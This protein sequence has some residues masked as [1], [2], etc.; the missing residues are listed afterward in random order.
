MVVL[1]PP[2]DPVAVPVADPAAEEALGDELADPDVLVE[3]V[4][5]PV[6]V[7]C[8][9]EDL[10]VR[11]D[12]ELREDD[13]DELREDDPV[14]PDERELPDDVERP[15]VDPVVPVV[16]VADPDSRV[17]DDALAELVAPES[18]A[19]DVPSDHL[20]WEGRPLMRLAT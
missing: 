4:A 15:V 11:E 3:L 20:S 16:P 18:S 5:A 9:P 1:V 19:L 7:D 6:A 10:L 12:E 14:D 8:D 17:L 13:D 2:Y